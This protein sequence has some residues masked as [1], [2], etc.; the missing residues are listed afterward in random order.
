ME[1]KEFDP[2][3]LN[4][5]KDPKAPTE[6]ANPDPTSILSSSVPN[7]HLDHL[8]LSNIAQE[9][10]TNP[11]VRASLARESVTEEPSSKKVDKEQ[12]G[13]S[14]WLAAIQREHSDRLKK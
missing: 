5:K 6:R 2:I 9:E 14:R 8:V 7:Q 3:T 12:S 13:G 1:G 4:I 10:I 11:L